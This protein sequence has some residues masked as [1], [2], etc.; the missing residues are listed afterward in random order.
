M[1]KRTYTDPRSIAL[2]SAL[3][4]AAAGDAVLAWRL[5]HYRRDN[6][7]LAAEVEHLSRW[8]KADMRRPHLRLIRGGA[9]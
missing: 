5:R 8:R 4:L 3:G 7:T 9:S 2:A 1:S 6:A